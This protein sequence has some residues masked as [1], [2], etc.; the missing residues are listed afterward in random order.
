[1]ANQIA[2]AGQMVGLVESLLYAQRVGLDQ[3][4]L[5]DSIKNGAA[6]SFSL[7]VYG[8]R[9]VNQDFL[10]GFYIQHFIKDMQIVIQECQTHQIHLPGL[11]L[12]K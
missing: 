9:I 6:A 12:V 3:T 7:N 1:M 4:L 5:I 8:P 10:P 11:T 2:I